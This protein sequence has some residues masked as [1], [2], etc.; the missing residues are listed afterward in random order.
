MSISDAQFI[1][2]TNDKNKVYNFYKQY[3]T[4]RL[5]NIYIEEYDLYHSKY[6]DLINR[7][8]N[9]EETKKS[10]RCIELQY[11]KFTWLSQNISDCEYIYWIDAG[12]CHSG[13][14][15]NKYLKVHTGN[16]YD[17]YY[18]SDIFTNKWINNINS[19][20]ADKVLVCAK[21]NVRNYWDGPV[22]DRYFKNS[23][24]ST[25][26]I[27]GGIF[28][29]NIIKIQLLT[30]YFDSLVKEILNNESRFYSEE[31]IFSCLFFNYP[32]LFHAENFDIWWHE[33][34]TSDQELLSNNKSFY[35]IIEK[36]I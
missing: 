8:K 28:G 31:Q 23:P 9:I 1:I 6:S 16:Y 5:D 30:K 26:H 11:S 29:G 32:E 35:R 22:P 7:I 34:N 14:F 10:D 2:Y 15:P 25:R 18:G 24:C 12:L 19:A 13:L 4:F 36:F 17:S 33:D 27:I 3:L 20:V 21:D